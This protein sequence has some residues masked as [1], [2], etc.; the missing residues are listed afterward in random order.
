MGRPATRQR[1]SALGSSLPDP[2]RGG[3]L[4][5]AK[6]GRRHGELRGDDR[7]ARGARA[8]RLPLIPPSRPGGRTY[9]RAVRLLLDP[10]DGGGEAPSDSLLDPPHP[11]GGALHARDPPSLL[12]LT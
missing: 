3:G 12:S 1:R 4:A 11:D 5:A 6:R 7:S 8:A 9:G 2:A 10:A